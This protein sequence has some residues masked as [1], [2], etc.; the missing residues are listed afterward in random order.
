MS[1]K[2]LAGL[3]LASVGIFS[4]AYVVLAAD[5]F[6]YIN[7]DS[8]EQVGKNININ[9]SGKNYTLT[10][11]CRD[12]GYGYRNYVMTCAS[13][14]QYKVEW[15]EGCTPV[16]PP[17]PPVVKDT[18]APKV[19]VSKVDSSY[20]LGDVFSTDFDATDNVKVTKMIVYR[21]GVKVKEVGSDELHY[22][23]VTNK[24]GTVNFR[25]YAYD[26]AGNVGTNSISIYV[27]NNTDTVAP[28]VSLTSD[29]KIYTEGN[30]VYLT[31]NASDNVSVQRIEMLGETEKVLR[32]CYNTSV[33]TADEIITFSAP[34]NINWG[35]ADYI[36][37]VYD[38]AGNVGY[39]HLTV[40]VN[41]KVANNLSI[42]NPISLFNENGVSWIKISGDAY[43]DSGVSSIEIYLGVDNTKNSQPLVKKCNF[44]GSDKNASCVLT[45]PRSLYHG[46]FFWARMTAKN[47][48]TKDSGLTYYNY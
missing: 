19:Y 45:F 12:A 11:A 38:S 22:S 18:E 24:L 25:V 5:G 1:K 43:A 9:R 3:I 20:K 29:K 48:S 33:C 44:N 46:G 34:A 40:E 8:C 6:N 30:R 17:S 39:G 42:N 10:S 41:R 31:A 7:V 35:I 26:A 27:T 13:K 23:Y 2:L 32:T 47:G 15:T 21:D 14:T 4:A 36:V 28:T 37:R 16:T